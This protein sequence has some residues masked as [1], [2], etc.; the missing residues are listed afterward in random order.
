MVLVTEQGEH[1]IQKIKQFIAIG[2]L[3]FVTGVALVPQTAYAEPI[4]PADSIKDG[5]NK[6][7]GSSAGGNALNRGLRTVVNVLLF[8]IGAIAVVMVVIGGLRYTLSAGDASAV[9]A[10][11]NTILYAIVGL[12]VAILAY[13][14]VN[15]VVDAFI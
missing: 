3:V 7:G 11:K 6:A 8:I 12:V 10:A 15:F 4:N 9:S 14:I 1:M 2:A 13:A 5:V